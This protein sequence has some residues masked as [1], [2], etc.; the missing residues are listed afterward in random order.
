M[1]LCGRGEFGDLCRVRP[2]A[3]EY[4]RAPS[5]R[6][7]PGL[8]RA[9]SLINDPIQLFEEGGRARERTPREVS[10]EALDASV[11]RPGEA[12]D[13]ECAEE[14]VWVCAREPNDLVFLART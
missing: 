13:Q 8:A 11:L 4:A 3:A 6:N 9:L 7:E 1:R 2:D 10:T 5:E 14:E 12:F